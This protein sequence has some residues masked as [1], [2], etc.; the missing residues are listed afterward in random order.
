MAKTFLRV[1]IKDIESNYNTTGLVL[2]KIRLIPDYTQLATR[3]SQII[4]WNRDFGSSVMKVWRVR[5]AFAHLFTYLLCNS[6]V[7]AS[8]RISHDKYVGIVCIRPQNVRVT[9]SRPVR[10]R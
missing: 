2:F 10:Y 4:A 8:C 9:S 3:L 1:E 6:W 5:G 7:K